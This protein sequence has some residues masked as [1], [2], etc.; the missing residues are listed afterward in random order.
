MI[1]V[2][3]NSIRVSLMSQQR[4]VL[5]K[6]L[7]AE[8]YLPIFIGQFEADNI[9]V[10]LQ[11]KRSV[12]RPLTH[13]LLKSVIEQMDGRLV[14]ILIN[15]LRRDIY[16]ARLVIEVRGE[17]I[18]V[19]ARPSDAIALAVRAKVGI[20]VSEAV[21]DKSGVKP[22]EEIDL[23]MTTET[24]RK[25]EP[26][27]TNADEPEESPDDVLISDEDTVGT[28]NES[29]LSAFADFLNTLDLGDLEDS[30]EN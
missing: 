7:D 17:T 10:E 9:T 24:K 2:E 3:V 21:M 18:E 22:D 5:L 23:Q 12:K 14:H 25:V 30:D 1:E 16:Y 29:Q 26:V 19:D 13:D 6:E 4:V 20:F 27:Q 15:D 11:D 8:R 28:V